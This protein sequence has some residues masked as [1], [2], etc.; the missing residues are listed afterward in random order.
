MHCFNQEDNKG[1]YIIADAKSKEKLDKLLTYAQKENSTEV[2]SLLETL[3]AQEHYKSILTTLIVAK[4]SF[5]A[6]SLP[7]QILK[8]AITSFKKENCNDYADNF[9]FLSV[10]MQNGTIVQKGYVVKILSEKLDDNQDLEQT[11]NLID[12]M[13]NISDFDSSGLLH[14]HLDRYQKDNKDS[15]MPDIS[16][17]IKGLKEKTKINK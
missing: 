2:F 16:D 5:F 13:E 10:I 1:I 9:E 3:I 12:T 17:K 8:L 6:N 14:S 4:D 15:I 11:L 7:Q